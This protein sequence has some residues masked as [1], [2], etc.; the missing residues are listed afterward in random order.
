MN[1]KFKYGD[2]IETK[3]HVKY[4]YFQKLGIKCMD[5]VKI[6]LIIFDGIVKHVY[7]IDK[8]DIKYIEVWW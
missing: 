6:N 7:M 4:I 2:I 1:I 5:A 3:Y 8:S